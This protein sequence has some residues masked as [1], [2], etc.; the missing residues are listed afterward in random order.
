MGLRLPPA[1]LLP[2]SSQ[3]LSP[4]HA[5]SSPPLGSHTEVS[6][7][8]QARKRHA[9]ELTPWGVAIA[10]VAA[11]M[12]RPTENFRR[13]RPIFSGLMGDV[14]RG[15]QHRLL[16]IRVTE[17]PTLAGLGLETARLP[18]PSD[19]DFDH[20]RARRG[21][22]TCGVLIRLVNRWPM[23]DDQAGGSHLVNQPE[24]IPRCAE[25]RSQDLPALLRHQVANHR[26]NFKL[27]G[28]PPHRSCDRQHR[29]DGLRLPGGCIFL[30]LLS[31]RIE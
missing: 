20:W 23:P 16:C 14:C 2:A 4:A 31:S 29:Q 9:D 8:Y 12:E 26:A 5:S 11:E 7:S 18:I 3:P 17:H 22:C 10:N 1:Q 27:S 21:A 6:H 19:Q 25:Y 28:L 30:D 13:A 24:R 15:Q